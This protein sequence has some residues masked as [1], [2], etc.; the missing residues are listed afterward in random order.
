[1]SLWG[2]SLPQKSGF[3]RA[4]SQL[5]VGGSDGAL[6]VLRDVELE[7]GDTVSLLL[8]HWKA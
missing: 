8:Y 6:E 5:R 1:M 3:N 4:L 2:E 7:E